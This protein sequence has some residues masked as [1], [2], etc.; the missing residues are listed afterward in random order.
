VYGTMNSMQLILK[1]IA[2]HNQQLLST[3]QTVDIK[4][5]SN[6]IFILKRYFLNF[7]SL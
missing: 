5:T 1:I 2:R 4:R 3:H 6:Q 7:P